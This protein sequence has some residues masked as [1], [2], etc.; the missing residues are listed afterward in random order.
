MCSFRGHTG[1]VNSL[2]FTPDGQRLVTGSRDRTVKI[3][4]LT[5]LE[6]VP[7]R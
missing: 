2:A 5:Q 4:D 7:D 3:W 1:L 6:E